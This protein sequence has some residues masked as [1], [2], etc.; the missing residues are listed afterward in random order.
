MKFFFNKWKFKCI[1]FGRREYRAREN[2]GKRLKKNISLTSGH[3]LVSDYLDYHVY[4]TW[5]YSKRFEKSFNSITFKYVC[6]QSTDKSDKGVF[7]CLCKQ[8]VKEGFLFLKLGL[9]R[10]ERK[11]S[12]WN[13]HLRA[14][15]QIRKNDR[16]MYYEISFWGKW[17]KAE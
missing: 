3:N 15:Y 4:Y 16:I 14:K 8:V 11:K 7:V 10:Q 6:L 1:I 9:M 2:G 13:R 17:I 12:S 5:K